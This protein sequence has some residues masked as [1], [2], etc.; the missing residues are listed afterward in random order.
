[1]LIGIRHTYPVHLKEKVI[2]IMKRS[3]LAALFA[4]VVSIS[5]PVLVSA[6]EVPKFTEHPLQWLSA[7]GVGVKD[8]AVDKAATYLDPGDVIAERDARILELLTELNEVKAKLT[9][10]DTRRYILKQDLASLVD[11]ARVIHTLSLNGSL[12]HLIHEVSTDVEV[13]SGGTTPVA[14]DTSSASPP[15][16]E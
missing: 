12:N 16:I 15:S 2:T 1:M 14:R 11:A 6:Q 9:V 3:M 13:T 7:V 8:A 5:L 4:A 10:E